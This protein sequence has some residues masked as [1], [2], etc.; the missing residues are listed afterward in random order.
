MFKMI[1]FTESNSLKYFLV[2]CKLFKTIHKEHCD[3]QVKARGT[4][5]SLPHHFSDVYI[6]QWIA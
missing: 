1:N 2:F 5:S 4:T 6:A 3:K